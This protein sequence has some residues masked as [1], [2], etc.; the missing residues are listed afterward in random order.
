MLRFEIQ[1]DPVFLVMLDAAIEYMIFGLDLDESSDQD[2]SFAVNMPR[3]SRLFT[4]QQA[5]EQLRGLQCAIHAPEMYK[6]TDY[7]WLLLYECLNRYC[8]LFNDLPFGVISEKYGIE[9]IDFDGVVDYFFWD[10][11]FLDEDISKLPM[12]A[13]EQLGV[14]PE[15]FGLSMG[16]TP[17]PEELVLKRC[18]PDDDTEP[19]KAYTPGSKTYP[20]FGN[21]YP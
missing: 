4:A 2:E 19:A 14:S 1:P 15:T 12:E 8:G 3:S 18:E 20:D 9:S 21:V 13:R 17:H 10:T 5:N 16:M 11:D 6:P 7:H